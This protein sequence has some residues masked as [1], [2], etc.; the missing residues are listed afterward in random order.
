MSRRWLTGENCASLYDLDTT[1]TSQIL[2]FLPHKRLIELLVPTDEW[3]QNHC[4][5]NLFKTSLLPGA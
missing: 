2:I 1:Q 5:L 3:E 4:S